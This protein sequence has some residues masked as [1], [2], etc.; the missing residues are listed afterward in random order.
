MELET[1]ELRD[2]PVLLVAW[3]YAYVEAYGMPEA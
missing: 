1:A 2:F 3:L